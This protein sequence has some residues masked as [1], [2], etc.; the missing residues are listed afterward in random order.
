MSGDR[1]RPVPTAF[2]SEIYELPA[3]WSPL[4]LIVGAGT[5]I[6]DPGLDNVLVV[7]DK[8]SK[9]YHLPWAVH[10]RQD[11]G[12]FVR[13][14]FDA[15]M[16]ETGLV[17]EKHPLPM[18]ERYYK[19][20]EARDWRELQADTKLAY[21]C[22]T[23]PFYTSFDIFWSPLPGAENS[24]WLDSRQRMLMWF[25]CRK[26]SGSPS[27]EN[28]AFMPLADA[29]KKLQDQEYPDTGGLGALRQLVDILAKLRQSPPPPPG[30]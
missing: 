1:V 20:P 27:S 26:I 4:D 3:C 11:I 15:I 18:V 10:N 6:L 7:Y 5:I 2:S 28:M 14:P 25:A 17:V 30:S 24:P 8:D 16:K 29:E 19:N 23:D 22:T 12:E 21:P 13:S 9:V